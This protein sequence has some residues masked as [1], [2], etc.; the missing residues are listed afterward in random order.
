MICPIPKSFDITYDLNQE[1]ALPRP[2]IIVNI[3]FFLFHASTPTDALEIVRLSGRG[4]G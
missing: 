1:R 3:L 4:I 2:I